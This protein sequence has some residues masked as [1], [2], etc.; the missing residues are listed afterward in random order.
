MRRAGCYLHLK[1]HSSDNNNPK[2]G[3]T[4]TGHRKW[5]EEGH[6]DVYGTC[7]VLGLSTAASSDGKAGR[8]HQNAQLA[9]NS[10]PRRM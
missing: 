10:L 9:L 5:A 8:Q 3:Q 1:A 7:R 2:Y 6:D 4:T